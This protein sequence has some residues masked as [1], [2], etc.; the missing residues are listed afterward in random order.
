MIV[1][2]LAPEIVL[3]KA[4]SELMAARSQMK[5]M[6]EFAKEDGVEW[7]LGHAFS[8][9]SITRFMGINFHIFEDRAFIYILD[10]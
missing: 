3:G 6:Q 5:M 4:L 1:I 10:F 8:N 9:W 7:D 2:V